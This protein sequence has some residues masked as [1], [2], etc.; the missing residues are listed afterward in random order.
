MRLRRTLELVVDFRLVGCFFSYY[1]YGYKQAHSFDFG[2]SGLVALGGW[3]NDDDNNITPKL[4]S[5][6]CFFFFSFITILG[7]FLER[8]TCLFCLFY[9]DRHWSIYGRYFFSPQRCP[10]FLSVI[11]FIIG[12]YYTR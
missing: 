4:G 12:S 5:T 2:T 3:M 11:Y 9:T 7:G 8:L 6:V 10:I 1:S